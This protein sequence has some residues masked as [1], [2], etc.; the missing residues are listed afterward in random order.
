MDYNATRW[1]TLGRQKATGKNISFYAPQN[2]L[3]WLRNLTHGKEEQVFIY[4]DG[5][6]IFVQDIR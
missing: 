5:K 4:Q 1:K 6:Q 3:L 2:V